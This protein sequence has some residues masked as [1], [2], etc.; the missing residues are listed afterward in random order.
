MTQTATAAVNHD[1]DLADAV[2]AH[3][4]R[5]PRVENFVNHLRAA[6]RFSAQSRAVPNLDSPRL[7]LRI[8]VACTERSH[9]RQAALLG[10]LG[11][12]HI[13]ERTTSEAC[14]DTQLRAAAAR[15]PCCGRRSACGRTPRS[16]PCPPPTRSPR[17]ATWQQA[18][19]RQH[20]G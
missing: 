15:A 16:A 7:N 2:D 9:L 11:H 1:A 10:A 18:H 20:H 6:R 14:G 8:V 3:L 4:V 13:Q 19:T 12:L 17:A 5:R